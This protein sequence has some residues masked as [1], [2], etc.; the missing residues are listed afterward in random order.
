[1]IFLICTAALG[2]AMLR[3]TARSLDPLEHVAY[4]A[5]LGHVLASGALL[6]LATVL[7][8]LHAFA[9][10]GVTAASAAA[11]F[12]GWLRRLGVRPRSPDRD[13]PAIGVRR[14]YRAVG[15]G[16]SV[17][18]AGFV[19][20][21]AAL[22]A[23]ALV[24]EEDGLWA[25]DVGIWADWAQHLGDVTSFA[26]GDNFPPGHPRFVGGAFAYH[27][28]VSVPAA[29]LV[30]YGVKPTWA[31]P[32]QGFTLT[33]FVGLSV[34]AFARRLTEDRGSAALALVVFLLGGG[35]G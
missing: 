14:L 9:V 29:A 10:I 1:M 15:A 21:W 4:G 20:V 32:L 27:Y 26:Y 3:R 16:P 12:W 2:V 35:W 34:F 5:P 25:N 24:V 30:R 8:R 17:V 6:A 28:L 13:E 19:V 23:G 33:V 11:V 7:G 22:A 31:L 18:L